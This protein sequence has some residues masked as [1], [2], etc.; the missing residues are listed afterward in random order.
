MKT[1][2]SVLNRIRTRFPQSGLRRVCGELLEIGNQAEA[3]TA[4]LKRPIY[5]IRAFSWLLIATL[6][7][8][9]FAPFFLLDVSLDLSNLGDL[10]QLI[11]ASL[12]E[13]VLIGLAILFLAT[14]ERRIKRQRVLR[15]LGELRSIAHVV[16]MHQLAKDPELVVGKGEE[17]HDVELDAM[18]RSDLARYLDYCSEVLAL[19][20]KVAALYLEAFEDSVVIGAVNEVENLVS[21]LSRKIWQKIMILDRGILDT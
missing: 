2:R 13:V 12:N 9:A 5:A 17:T 11:E 18:D 14:W 8:L 21:G 19:T 7:M 4:S 6:V 1:I 10:I 15:A 20:S 3:F 16:D